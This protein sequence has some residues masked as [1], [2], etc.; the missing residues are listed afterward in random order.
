MNW[1]YTGNP[2]F[3]GV[4]NLAP[5]SPPNNLFPNGIFS[6][7]HSSPLL[8]SYPLTLLFSPY[9]Q[10][11]NMSLAGYQGFAHG[12]HTYLLGLDGGNTCTKSLDLGM[13]TQFAGAI[14]CKKPLRR[15][16]VYTQVFSLFS[17]CS[18]FFIYLLSAR[19][20]TLPQG[21][22]SATAGTMKL[23]VTQGG[24]TLPFGR[25]L[26][27]SSSYLFP[28]ILYIYIFLKGLILTSK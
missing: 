27:P 8:H 3:G 5:N 6:S 24:V 14:L 10:N 20:S 11:A 17:I 9:T 1:A 15:L 25:F 21:F 13:N 26:S 4:F 2:V 22:S 19:G 7:L 16:E 12:I 28:P 23:L 18:L